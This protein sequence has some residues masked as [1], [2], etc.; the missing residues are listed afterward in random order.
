MDRREA[1][2]CLAALLDGELRDPRQIAELNA[3]LE[4]DPALRAEYE[5]QRVLKAALGGL[6]PSEQQLEQQAPSFMATRVMGEIAARRNAPRPSLWRPVVTWSGSLAALL[7]GFFTTVQF[8][9]PAVDTAAL[10][11]QSQ[12][13][14]SAQTAVP[15]GLTMNVRYA[16]DYWNNL[17][18]PA[19]TDQRV[20]DFLKF[21][22][23]AHNYR[24]LM[25]SGDDT[26]PDMAQAVM[27][28]NSGDTHVVWAADGN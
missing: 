6:A 25:R 28:V 12:A 24:R 4:R 5:A 20:A 11:A 3:L 9:Q 19:G 15:A 26:T 22:N 7:I 13:V 21:A 23:E 27:A 8:M 1:E 18:V 14:P 10:T 2:N 16:P 17:S